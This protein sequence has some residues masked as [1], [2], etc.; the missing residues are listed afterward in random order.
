VDR[1][2]VKAAAKLTSQG[3]QLA[4]S[5]PGFRKELSQYLVLP[6]SRKKRGIAVKSLHV[7]WLLEVMEPW[8]IRLGIG[9][10]AEA[11]LEKK[12][13]LSASAII[14]ITSIGD[15]PKYWFEVGRTYLRVSLIVE[16]HSLSQATSAAVVEASDFHED[17]EKLM[18][19]KQRI[20]SMMRIGA[21]G[22]PKRYHSPRLD[23]EE[24]IT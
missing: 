9:L 20:Q 22:A 18:H 21:P 1:D 19:T 24:L 8:L 5:S 14:V 11:D 13:W 10:K 12:R 23:A 15:M 4:L 3:I 6:W 17:V 2:V 16:K 7:S